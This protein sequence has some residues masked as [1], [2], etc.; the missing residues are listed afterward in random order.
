MA[1]IRTFAKPIWLYRYRSL[2]QHLPE[3]EAN[4]KF[5]RE[6][7]AVLKNKVFCG[8]F[9]SLNDPMEGLY[10][11]ST[12]AASQSNFRDIA[13]LIMS[14]QLG[15][16]VG[17]FSETWDNTIMW[18]H[19]ADQFCG[20]CVC[21][22]LTG[23]LKGMPDDHYF[24]RMAYGDKLPLLNL[25]SAKDPEGRARAILS[26]KHLNWQYERE[27]RLFAPAVGL[28]DYGE[29]V[30]KSVY[31]GPR[32]PNKLQARVRAALKP[33][34]IPVHTTRTDAYTLTKVSSRPRAK[35]G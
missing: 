33:L 23:L 17:S 11:A 1:E 18:A 2:G 6:I 14:E 12:R 30:V 29:K 4:K 35:S 16:G 25:P 5:D 34:S 10:E 28:A 15:I 3:S 22:G 21:Y 8:R 31:L 24:A 20:I 32:M 9:D 7:E 26:R 19:Y 13:R 27:W